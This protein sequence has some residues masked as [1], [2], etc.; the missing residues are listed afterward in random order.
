[1]AQSKIS[2]P[3]SSEMTDMSNNS[4]FSETM[5]NSTNLEVQPIAEQS[6]T[7]QAKSTRPTAKQRKSELKESGAVIFEFALALFGRGAR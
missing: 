6:E 2:N 7:V 3:Q 1:M 4:I 5:E